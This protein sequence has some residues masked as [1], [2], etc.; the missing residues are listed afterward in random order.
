MD[1][2]ESL[3]GRKIKDIKDLNKIEAKN[4]LKFL[5]SHKYEHLVKKYDI[6]YRFNQN[7]YDSLVSFAYNYRGIDKLTDYGKKTIEEISKSIIN[8]DF[9]TVKG[10]KSDGLENRRKLEKALFDKSISTNSNQMIINSYE[11]CSNSFIFSSILSEKGN[12]Q[13]IGGDCYSEDIGIILYDNQKGN[14]LKTICQKYYHQSYNFEVLSCLSYYPILEGVY[15]IKLEKKGIFS[16]GDTV[17]PFDLTNNMYNISTIYNEETEQ[18]EEKIEDN[19]I[20][21]YNVSFP[22]PFYFEHN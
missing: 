20:K 5:I 12:S 9:M 2:R 3:I 1:L 17:L 13:K 18:Y 7:Q 19:R 21:I 6:I 10:K 11:R 14:I 15:I 8:Y 4:I 16:N 22:L